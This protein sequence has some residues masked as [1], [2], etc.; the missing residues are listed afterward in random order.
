MTGISYLSRQQESTARVLIG[1][2]LSI[3]H[4]VKSSSSPSVA[5]SVFIERIKSRVNYWRNACKGSSAKADGKDYA[6]SLIISESGISCSILFLSVF[7]HNLQ[8]LL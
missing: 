3:T 5:D 7:T 6:D 2:P 8:T 4:E 1:N